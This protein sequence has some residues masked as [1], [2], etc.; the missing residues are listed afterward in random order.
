MKHKEKY[1]FIVHLVGLIQILTFS[2]AFSNIRQMWI[3]ILRR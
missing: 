1:D 3:L 2:N